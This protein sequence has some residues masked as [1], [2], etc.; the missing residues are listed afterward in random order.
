MKRTPLARKTPLKRAAMKRTS[1]KKASKAWK[2]DPK[3]LARVR[4]LPCVICGKWGET[5]AH[6]P[7]NGTGMGL[8]APDREAVAL[9]SSHHRT[10]GPGIAFHATGRADWEEQWGTQADLTERTLKM[11]GLSGESC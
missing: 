2:D 4:E 9:C 5:E 7:R 3:H 11:L 6:H 8:K 10:G 1:K